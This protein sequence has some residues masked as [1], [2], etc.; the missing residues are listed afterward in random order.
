MVWARRVVVC[1]LLVAVLSPLLVAFRVWYVARQDSTPRSDALIVLGAAQYNGQ[2]SQVFEWRLRH[3]ARLYKEGVA[4]VVVTVGGGQPGDRFT[5]AESGRRW[6]A[7]HGV[8]AKKVVAVATGRDTEQSLQAVG[9][10]FRRRD[11][12]SAVLVSDPWHALRTRTMARDQG[13]EA[14]TSPTRSGPIVQTRSTQAR[15]IVRE[16]GA[17]L[18]YLIKRD[19]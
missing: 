12:N 16:T 2:P 11:W 18:H 5:E 8:P 3:A 4:P 15:Y 7:A 14:A 17:Y 19:R 9:R 13:I 10:E 1:T 6:L